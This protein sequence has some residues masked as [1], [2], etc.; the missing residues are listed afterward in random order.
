MSLQALGITPA[1]LGDNVQA[2]KRSPKLT[3]NR[4]DA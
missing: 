2:E 4:D 3:P 1:Q